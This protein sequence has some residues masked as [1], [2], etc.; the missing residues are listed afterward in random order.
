MSIK[1]TSSLLLASLLF[2]FAAC[3]SK[4]SAPTPVDPPEPGP[5]P[6]PTPPE[7]VVS[8]GAYKHVFIIGV[9]GGGAYFRETNTPRC[10][11]IFMHQATTYQS[12]MALPT[13]SAQGWASILH[14]VLP[15]FHGCTN[16][17]IAANP[18]PKN[19]RYPSIFRVV[20]EAMPDAELAS[21]VE[22][23]PINIGIVE[24]G[25]GVE[26]QTGNGD[27]EVIGKIL[28]YLNSKTPTLMFV[29]LSSP[30]DVGESKGF[31]SDI[32]L[33][34]LSTVDALVGGIYDKLKQKE[35][36]DETLFIV[37]AD[38]G[39]INKT[40]GGDSDLEKYV[41]MGVAGK[42]V[43]HSTIVGAEGR[44]VAA[45]AAYALGLDNPETWTGR[46]P[47]GVFKDVPVADEHQE[48]DLP[49]T[50]YRQ[51][52]EDTPDISIIQAVFGQHDVIAY[53]PFD[54]SIDDAYGN[55]ETSQSGTIQYEDAYFGKGI[56]LNNGYVT[57]KD[58]KVGTGSFS[59][60]LWLKASPI[61]PVDADPSI[62]S[63]KNWQEGVYKGFILSYR[64]SKDT[65]FNV[66]NGSKG[67][68]DYTRILPSNYDEGW[69]HV[70]LT[71][72]RENRKVRIYYDFVF[73][74]EEAEIP[75]V[76]ASTSFDSLTLNLGQDGTGKLSY[77]LPAQMD[78]FIMTRD[79]LTESDVASLKTYYQPR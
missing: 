62:I 38:H 28:N 36:L 53:L 3:S 11:E 27:A 48:Q 33:A 39:G 50:E 41:F 21:F 10:D 31:G 4:D 34:T 76:L 40:H 12:L 70:I 71:V 16:D 7:V 1:S 29:Q 37:T 72:D 8:K 68:M 61:T 54:E 25:F 51:H 58:V 55:I 15:K 77:K 26:K 22:W 56:V 9:D 35:I 24:D 63:N 32:Y 30:D 42:T 19:S 17:I 59:V 75:D 57:L 79:V 45:I 5:E 66:G 49:G 20:R 64:G 43:D 44:D 18:Y 73:E 78:E 2:F 47:G 6:E 67:R 60:A 46:L 13:M 65:K 69:M 74:G 14:G 52:H 23:N